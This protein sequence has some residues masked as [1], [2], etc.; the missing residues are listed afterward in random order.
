MIHLVTFIV[1]HP[2]MTQ[3][4]MAAF[5]YNKGSTLYSKQR[6]S[7]HL[8]NLEITK[9]KASFEAFQALDAEVQ[10]RVF[11][12]WNCPPPNLIFKVHQR[13][14]IDID[15][16]GVRLERCNRTSG[17]ALKVF[18]VQK[19]GNY[20]HGEKPPCYL[21]SSQAILLWS[22]RFTGASSILGGGFGTF[23]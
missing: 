5:V 6:I 11:T 20:G 12:F 18:C 2:E 1:P 17:W 13:K 14:L 23:G 15:V 10:F 21:P 16:F 9:K 3:D 7:K 4:K 8:D 22:R 19:D